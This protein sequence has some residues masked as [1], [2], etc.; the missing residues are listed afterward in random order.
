MVT[1]PIV[2]VGVQQAV[3]P[4]PLDG[5]ANT[6]VA[7]PGPGVLV[8]AADVIAV[9]FGAEC[10][11]CEECNDPKDPARHDTTEDGPYE[12]VSSG[13]PNIHDCTGVDSL[14]PCSQDHIMT[15]GCNIH[16]VDEDGER[17]EAHDILNEVAT[18]TVEEL[19][20]LL[21]R[22]AVL[23]TFNAARSAIQARGCSG[24][25]IAHLPLTHAAM[26]VLVG[27]RAGQ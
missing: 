4:A 11:E 5:L 10:S 26:G 24:Q 6:M 13:H 14:G 12:L 15:V 25:I 21:D 2:A 9:P 16:F 1:L 23:L 22:Y 27:A 19:K 20:P 18:A 8:M 7:A 3:S 17:V